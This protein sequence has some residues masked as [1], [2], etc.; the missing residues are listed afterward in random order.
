MKVIGL[1]GGMGSG[2]S[3]VA[4]MFLALGAPVVDADQIARA[5]RA[6][7]G[8]AH[9][10]I[11]STFGTDDPTQLRS[12]LSKDPESKKRLEAI[13][14]P[15]IRQESS[16]AIQALAKKHPEAPFILYEAALLLEAGRARDFNGVVLVTAP[17]SIKISRIMTRDHCS[18]EQAR[19]MLKA[20]W[21]DQEREKQAQWI[22]PN[23]G[24]LQSLEQAVRSTFEKIRLCELK[25]S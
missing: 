12:I 13:L 8:L 14:H 20:Q 25:P 19:A 2:K 1:T 5:L 10:Q 18:E 15:L 7:G 23:S 4:K 24:T 3:T 21:T 16:K 22:I 17:D 9:S 6:P 11:L